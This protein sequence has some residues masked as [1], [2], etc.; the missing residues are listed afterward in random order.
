MK[1]VIVIPSYN[2]RENIQDIITAIRVEKFSV[3]PHILVV[4]SASPDQTA[5]I[6]NNLRRNDPMLFLVSQKAKMGLGKAYLD[7]MHWALE[8][9]YDCL[10]TMD[11]DFSHHPKYLHRLLKEIEAHDLV[12]GSRYI[13]GG[14]LK[15]WPESRRLLSRFANWYARTLMGLPFSDL[16]SGFHCFRTE[17]LKKILENRIH[18]EGYAFLME[19]KYMALLFGA[20]FC[21][22]PI[23]FSDRTKGASK[24]SKKV[25][26]ESALFVLKRI[27]QPKLLLSK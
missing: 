2:E 26:L 1:P 27:G 3:T 25:I 13:P 19:L 18:T 20:R 15:N 7:G 23:I 5:E 22:V 4:D 11:A 14:E 17:M 9:D 21:E 6:V 12:I 10:I 8:R 24:I 16:T